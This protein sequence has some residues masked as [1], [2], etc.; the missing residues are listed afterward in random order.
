MPYT[1]SI[2]AA[3]IRIAPATS[4]PWLT[5]GP[6]FSS[7]S[8]APRIIVATPIGRLMKKIQCQFSHWVRN[9]PASSPSEPPP[10]IT[11]VKT[12]I[13]WARSA[14]RW[15]SV[16]MIAMITPA[17]I[18]APRPCRKRPM[19][20]WSALWAKPLPTDA[21]VNRKTPARKTLRRPIRSPMACDQQEAS[22]ADQVGVDDPGQVRLA[23]TEV[24]LDPGQG[25]VDDRRVEHDHELPEAHDDQGHPPS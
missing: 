6:S 16:T 25:D 9:P 13:A 21:T 19:I 20:R 10:A 14:G 23:E 7:I 8:Q 5:P 12:L 3:V 2:S 1:P 11:R 18:E 24:H 4:T 17:E 15:N 22:V